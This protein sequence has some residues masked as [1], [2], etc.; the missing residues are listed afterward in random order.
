MGE[1]AD[2]L[3]PLVVLVVREAVFHRLMGY[4]TTLLSRR[5]GAPWLFAREQG[6]E[7]AFGLPNQGRQVGGR[8]TVG[9]QVH[10]KPVFHQIH[11]VTNGTHQ[12]VVLAA[13]G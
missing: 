6:R 1:L 13:M 10:F 2:V 4:K 5:E 8:E 12:H 9:L 3:Q 7:V 11:V